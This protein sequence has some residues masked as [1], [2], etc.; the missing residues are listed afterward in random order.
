M[1]EQI[2]SMQDFKYTTEIVEIQN[3]KI[4]AEIIDDEVCFR[5]NDYVSSNNMCYVSTIYDIKNEP[6]S[7]DLG[8]KTPSTINLTPPKHKVISCKKKQY[9]SQNKLSVKKLFR[10]KICEKSFSQKGNLKTHIWIHM[11]EK[12]YKCF[13]CN[14]SFSQASTLITHKLIHNVDKPFNCDICKKSY[15]Q[16][17]NLKTHLMFYLSK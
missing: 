10:C 15:V 7:C 11:Q 16:K 6:I 14:K 2:R 3:I 5:E 4:E 1:G 8:I 9:S 17:V 12:P 13:I